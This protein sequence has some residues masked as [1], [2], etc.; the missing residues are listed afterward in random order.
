MIEKHH[1][2]WTERGLST[3]IDAMER[4]YEINIHATLDGMN[5]NDIDLQFLV[6]CNVLF[7]IVDR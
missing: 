7:S 3:L 2:D 4:V 5:I 6:T 1:F